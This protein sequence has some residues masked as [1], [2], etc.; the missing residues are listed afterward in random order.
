M[1][2]KSTWTAT[3]ILTALMP[4]APIAAA[5]PRTETDIVL[6]QDGGRLLARYTDLLTALQTEIGKALP[7]VDEQSRTACQQ[8]REA[9]KSA[10]AAATAARQSLEKI[11]QAKG[12]VDHAKGKWIGGADKGIAQAEAD[13]KKASTDGERE[14]ARKDL[15]KWRADKA[16]GVQ[17]LKERQEA[18]DRVKT[19]EP[20]LARAN[21]E[22]QA[23]LTRARGNEEAA[24]RAMLKEVEPFLS[25][26]RLDAGLVVC[27]VLTEATPRG[28]A[29]FAQQGG[30]QEALVERLL[31]DDDLM[32]RMLIAGGARFGRYGRA[33]EIFT[34]IQA[35]SPRARDG[36][37]QRLALAV[38]LEHAAPVE[39]SNPVDQPKGPTTVDPV[40]RYLHYEKAFLAG[41]LDPAFDRFDVWEYR[42]VVNCDAPDEILS[43]GRDMLRN[44]RPDHVS[45]PDY[46][47]R[48]VAAVRTEVRYGSQN[49]KDDRPSLHAYQNIPLN[50][51][52]CGRR[53][54]FGRF[55]LRAFGIPVW[56]V[57]QHKHAA[58]SHWTPKGWVVNLGAGFPHSWWDRDES[59]RSG[60]DFLLETQARARG[61]DYLKV[62]RAQWVSRVLGEEAYNDRKGIAGGFWSALAHDQAVALAAA[63]VGLGP[64][65]QELAEANEPPQSRGRVEYGTPEAEPKAGVETG[66]VITITAANRSSGRSF[67]LMNAHGGGAQVHASGGFKADYEIAVPRA[68]TYAFTATVVTVQD[69]QVLLLA[70]TRQ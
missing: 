47:W 49:V 36:L 64:L 32:E 25:D 42:M 5:A 61:R 65:G 55:I 13:L 58:L 44:Y 23:A 40:K 54:F 38:A 43:W 60:S 15:A 1:N 26:D 24:A 2:T 70:A 31:A 46:G 52:V 50:G 39:Q 34:A 10:E 17:A 68:G 27:A 69:G 12:L 30:T 8:A 14:A 67:A 59:S 66:G 28:L 57:T 11:Q 48:Y 53:A 41:E 62:L 7:K 6:T 3:A 45:N 4:A 21:E 16:A 22:A 20:K 19:D 33:L 63:A 51:G 37:F 56:G 29:A 9:V 35:A 18:L